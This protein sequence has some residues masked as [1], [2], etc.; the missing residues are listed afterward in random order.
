MESMQ[1]DEPASLMIGEGVSRS[2]QGDLGLEW[3]RSGL[4]GF[5]GVRGHRPVLEVD[6]SLLLLVNSGVEPP[7][8]RFGSGDLADIAQHLHCR[9]AR[10]PGDEPPQ[11]EI[12]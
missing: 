8:K 5:D 6:L 4:P 7:L 12:G 1:F 9:G 2:G 3:S 11:V 10:E